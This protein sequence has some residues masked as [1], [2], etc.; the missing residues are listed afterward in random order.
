VEI[1]EANPAEREDFDL[2]YARLIMG[3]ALRLNG[4]VAQA[5]LYLREAEGL[6]NEMKNAKDKEIFM[7]D[8]RDALVGYDR[9][10]F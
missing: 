9:S 6:G 5:E 3:M 4:D 10:L 2:P 7:G 1:T 8:L